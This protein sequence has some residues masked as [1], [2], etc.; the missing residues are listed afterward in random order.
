M[1]KGPA[2]YSIGIGGWEHEAFDAC[3]YSRRGAESLEK[4]RYYARFFGLVEV[5]PTFWDDTLRANDASQWADAVRENRRF[6]FSV[7][8]HQAF[9]HKK[10]LNVQSAR[11]MRGILQ[12]LAK[13]DRLGT[14][15]MQ[16]PYSFTNT[17]ANR[18]HVVKLAQ[19]FS[20]F[21]LHAEFRHE[22][23]NQPMLEGFLGETS[24]GIVATD[25][26]RVKQFMAF[27]TSVVGDSAYVRL[28]GRNE[29]GWLLNTVD[30]RYD[31]LYNEREMREI[32]RRVSA[33]AQK[34]RRLSIIFNNTT[35]GKGIANAFQLSASLREGKHVLMPA[36]TLA[37]FPQLH[38]IAGGADAEHSLL[39]A[40][41]YRQA[42]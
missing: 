11:R 41:E 32:G 7:K 3:F 25:L 13:Q 2:T 10:Q 21:P 40:S 17:S 34:C 38:Q 30:G 6:L 35:G 8:L 26:P 23:W 36:A 27:A 42:M 14:V 15:L 20:G 39:G 37:A 28:H 9:T 31:Y 4:L 16:F 24:L 5:R 22:S 19:L 29:K 1:D 12:E 33:L 18:F